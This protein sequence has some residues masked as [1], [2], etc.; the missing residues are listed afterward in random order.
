[1]SNKMTQSQMNNGCMTLLFCFRS[2]QIHINKKNG[3]Y[4]GLRKKKKKVEL[5]M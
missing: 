2:S 1:M 4:E 5:S 3:G